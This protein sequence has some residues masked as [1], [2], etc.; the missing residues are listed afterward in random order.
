MNI[1]DLA[2][3]EDDDIEFIDNVK[4]CLRWIVIENRPPEV[5]L[6]KVDSWFGSRWCDFSGKAIGS[7]G[8]WRTK[9]TLPPFVP[10]RV[11]WERKFEAPRYD[12]IPIRRLLH[13]HATSAQAQ[14]RR[15]SEIA[16]KASFVWFSGKSKQNGRAS[17]MAYV[18]DNSSYW[19]WYTGW[20]GENGWRIC[21]TNGIS[22][23]KFAALTV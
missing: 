18:K 4:S 1:L 16:P 11:V 13:V 17:L 21:E 9:L 8:S 15:V 14:L 10:H 22:V 23:E 2:A 7:I 5:Y 12:Q 3:Q 19:T 20:N 6:I